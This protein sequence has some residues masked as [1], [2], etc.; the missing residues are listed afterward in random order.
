M[1]RHGGAA[2]SGL[3][4]SSHFCCQAVVQGHTTLYGLRSRVQIRG[5]RVNQVGVSATDSA[6]HL[7]MLQHSNSIFAEC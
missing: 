2:G 1:M 6:W 5:S 4:W 7:T 3:V